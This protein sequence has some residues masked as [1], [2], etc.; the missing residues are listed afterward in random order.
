MNALGALRRV[1]HLSELVLNR[2]TRDRASVPGKRVLMGVIAC[3]RLGNERFGDEGVAR[4]RSVGQKHR[5][6]VGDELRPGDGRLLRQAEQLVFH[7][8]ELVASRSAEPLHAKQGNLHA[9]RLV[10]VS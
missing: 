10:R 4:I 5:K 1:L 2:H 9:R 3:E 7:H 8:L 6:Q